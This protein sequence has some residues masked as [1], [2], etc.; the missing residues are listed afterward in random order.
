MD[1]GGVDADVNPVDA[2]L[3][4]PDDGELHALIDAT[5][6]GPQ[7]A[8]R[9]LAWTY[10]AA[11]GPLTCAHLNR[12]KLAV[13]GHLCFAVQAQLDQALPASSELSWYT[14]SFAHFPFEW[15]VAEV[16]P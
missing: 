10:G 3:I 1:N 2:A 7:I 8:P 15:Q 9:L 11:E 14:S 12:P 4:E 5:C 16:Q 13:S 6:H